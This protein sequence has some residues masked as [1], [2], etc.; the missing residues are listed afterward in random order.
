MVDANLGLRPVVADV[1]IVVVSIWTAYDAAEESVSS[2]PF[3]DVVDA[4]A[5]RCWCR[6]GIRR[7][8]R[9]G[10]YDVRD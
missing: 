7:R 4:T 10:T 8:I 6:V 5:S 9:I 2:F 1:V 3:V